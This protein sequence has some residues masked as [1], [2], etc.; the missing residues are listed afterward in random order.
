MSE[1]SF[2]GK[3]PQ[4]VFLRTVY[5]H[6]GFRRR[7]VIVGPSPGVDCSIIKISKDRVLALSTDPL[8]YIPELGAE[9]SAYLSVCSLTADLVTTGLKPQ[10]ATLDLNLPPQMGARNFAD[11]WKEVSDQLQRLGVSIVAGHT[12]IYEGC[13]YTIVGGGT[14]LSVGPARRYVTSSG[15]RA[16]NRLILT[17]GAALEGSAVLAKVFPRTVSERAGEEACRQAGRMFRQISVFDDALSAAS[18]GLRNAG[19][20]AM[21]D[22]AEGG[23]FGALLELAEA[24]SLGIRVHKERIPVPEASRRICEAFGLD[25]YTTLGGGALLIACVQ[26]RE[27]LV[28]RALNGAG[29]NAATIGELTLRSMGNILVEDG[30]EAR[31][32][33]ERSDKYWRVYSEAKRLGL[34]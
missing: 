9:D 28:L 26:S 20:T 22:V 12:G 34:E 7:G 33:A 13:D 3:I 19:V 32:K 11:Y 4:D 27:K 18:V 31:L 17:K 10:Y 15:G 8:S 23:V 25:P 21:H 16:G 2:Y 30:R 29:I 6:L 14:L 24:S 5:P 1:T